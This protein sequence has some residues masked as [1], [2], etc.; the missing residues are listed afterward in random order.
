MTSP[1]PKDVGAS[2]RARRAKLAREINVDSQLRLTIDADQR[3]HLR[4]ASSMNGPSFVLKG[5]PLFALWTAK[6][7]RATRKLD[8][9]GLGDTSAE[10]LHTVLL[11]ALSLRVPDAATKRT[12][13]SGLACKSSA[14]MS[15]HHPR[16]SRS[17]MHSPS[18]RLRQQ[19]GGF[20]LLGPGAHLVAGSR[21]FDSLQELVITWQSHLP[22]LRRSQRS[23]RPTEL[24]RRRDRRQPLLP[25]LHERLE[26]P[27]LDIED[28]GR[29]VERTRF[30]ERDRALVATVAADLV[31]RQRIPIERA[32]RAQLR[33]RAG[34]KRTGRPAAFTWEP[35]S[36]VAPGNRPGN[37]PGAPLA[38]LAAGPC[39]LGTGP[40]RAS[41]RR[42]V[43]IAAPERREESAL[44]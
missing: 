32:A 22:K 36:G 7:H 23:P 12:Q 40:A 21:R 11:E 1:A 15:G 4:I 19:P 33:D 28:Q 34:S 35:S 41:S 24:Q 5:A 44:T 17:G 10:H 2:V 42:A 30:L 14:A 29:A 18:F 3:L 31:A 38:A 9:L 13:G 8:P 27:A 20:Q 26:L 16:R 37:S 25:P 6:P 43:V 39:S